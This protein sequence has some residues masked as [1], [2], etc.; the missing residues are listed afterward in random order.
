E[1]ALA[2]TARAPRVRA[3]PATAERLGLVEGGVASV[4]TD[5]GAITLPVELADLPDGVVWLPANSPGSAVRSTLGVGHG[6]LVR[7]V[8]G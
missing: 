5:R 1:P 2:G 8:A 3:N 7:V 6:A 4:A